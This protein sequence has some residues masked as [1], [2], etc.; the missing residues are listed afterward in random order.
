MSE[1]Y[2]V[3]RSSTGSVVKP[4]WRHQLYHDLQLFLACL[5]NEP[6]S[7]MDPN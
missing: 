3:E 5:R 1:V 6:A 2:M 4:T 7:R